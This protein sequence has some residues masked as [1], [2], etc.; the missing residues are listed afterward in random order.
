MTFRCGFYFLFF[1]RVSVSYVNSSESNSPAA[2]RCHH[3]NNNKFGTFRG[4]ILRHIP[5]RAHSVLYY[6]DDNN[7]NNILSERR[8]GETTEH[9][10]GRWKIISRRPY[11]AE[12]RGQTRSIPSRRRGN[13]D[14][15]TWISSRFFRRLL[16]LLPRLYGTLVR[17]SVFRT[18]RFPELPN[19]LDTVI[20]RRSIATIVWCTLYYSVLSSVI[21]YVIYAIKY[22]V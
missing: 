3:N 14:V 1:P 19:G 15:R 5:M 8:R 17:P 7:N 20:T 6:D 10:G 2:H 12:S 16:A 11:R 18:K 9:F 21:V 22:Y 13:G 4:R